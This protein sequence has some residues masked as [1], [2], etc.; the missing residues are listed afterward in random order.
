MELG[1]IRAD[2]LP[3]GLPRNAQLPADLLNRL[4]LNEKRPANLGDRFHNQHSNLGLLRIRR[5]MWT[6]SPGVP[7]GCKSPPSGVLIP[8]KFTNDEA[9]LDRTAVDL[10]LD[11]EDRINL[12]H[13]FE[14]EW[15]NDGQLAACL[16]GDIGEHKELAPR[17]MAWIP[18]LALRRKAKQTGAAT[19]FQ[20]A[21][22][23]S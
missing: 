4:L 3:H 19:S 12:L 13:R 10:A 23:F 6:L 18:P 11:V 9:F 14:R 22:M 7:I 17:V 2:N 15:R 8:C 16:C 1:R 5:P 21:F 20:E